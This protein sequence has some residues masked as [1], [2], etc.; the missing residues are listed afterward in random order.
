MK[1]ALIR[2][3]T[4]GILAAALVAIARNRSPKTKQ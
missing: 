4:V 1:T 3:V 2:V